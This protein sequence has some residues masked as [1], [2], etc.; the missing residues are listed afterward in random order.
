MR[1]QTFCLIFVLTVMMSAT[2][3]V[4]AQ[5]ARPSVKAAEVNGT[6]KMNF[7]GKFRKF[8]NEIKILALGGGK[9]RFAMDLVYPY[10]MKNG[11][12]MVNMGGLDGEASIVGDT[13]NYVSE[14]GGCKFVF[15]FVKPGT[16][17][18]TED[19]TDGGCG[20]GHNVSAQG[21][22][23]KVSRLKPTFESV[24]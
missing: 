24:N 7:N 4:V 14:D 9:I 16:I 19:E 21:T 10:S 8:S 22:Y 1:K 12:P 6:F 20:F 23:L 17:K 5:A 2:M 11:E 18:I 13:A 3:F 15:K